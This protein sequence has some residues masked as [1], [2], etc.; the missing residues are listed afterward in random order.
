VINDPNFGHFD[1]I[2]EM[3]FCIRGIGSG[4]AGLDRMSRI[5][6]EA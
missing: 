5:E 2:L 1:A 6:T 3:E 4:I